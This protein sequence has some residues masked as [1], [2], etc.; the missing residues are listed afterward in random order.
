MKS[1][2]IRIGTNNKVIEIPWRPEMNVQEALEAAYD[3]EKLIHEPF[4][5]AI[6]YFGFWHQEYLGY[7][8]VMVDGVYD[9]P[10]N[11]QDYW[12]YYV[13]GQLAQVGIDNYIVCVDDMIEFDYHKTP[14][15]ALLASRQHKIKQ[16]VYQ[17]HPVE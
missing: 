9:N 11:Q 7:L 2:K 8:V 4:T 3:H 17:K 14:D 10:N 6:Q 15:E 16:G 1:V 13:N 12:C 5:F